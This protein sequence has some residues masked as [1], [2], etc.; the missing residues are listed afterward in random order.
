MG[1]AEEGAS[2]AHLVEEDAPEVV[3]VGEDLVLARQERPAAVHCRRDDG[4]C[5]CGSSPYRCLPRTKVHA[6]QAVLRRNLL[7]AEVLL[8]RDRV[9]RP[10]LDR[11]VVRDDHDFL[12]AQSPGTQHAPG[13]A[14]TLTPP[15]HRRYARITYPC[16]RP[17]PVM[18]PPEGTLSPS[19]RSQPASGESSRKGEPGSKRPLIR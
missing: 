9:V 4:R 10:A 16:T 14:A 8:D 1:G 11:R 13:V 5:A 7:R 17:I 2:W 15:R 6:G 18:T 12:P 3:S 19:Y